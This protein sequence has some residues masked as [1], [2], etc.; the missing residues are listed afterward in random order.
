MQFNLIS[1]FSF[2]PLMYISALV[3]YMHAVLKRPETQSF[4]HTRTILMVLLLPLK[5]KRQPR[6]QVIK[7]KM[8]FIVNIY[9]S[10]NIFKKKVN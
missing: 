10:A 3:L 5:K 4:T 8:H 1:P 7:L 9:L 2:I 6:L